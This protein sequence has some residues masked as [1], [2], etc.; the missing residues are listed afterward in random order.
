MTI[1]VNLF[2]GPGAGKSTLAY[3]LTGRLKRADHKAELVVEYAKQL[4][5]KKS[6]FEFT[7]QIFLIAQHNH[8]LKMLQGQVDIVVCDC[9]FL[10]TL[11]YTDESAT[12]EHK[13][14]IDLYNRYNNVGFIIPRRSKYHQYGRSQT[15]EEAR[16]LDT[17]IRQAVSF[18]PEEER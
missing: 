11:I 10:N 12:V 2:G 8:N 5:Y 4:A 13:L 9:S 15:E 17:K 3:E 7:D 1:V 6:H 16:L 14:S 18:L